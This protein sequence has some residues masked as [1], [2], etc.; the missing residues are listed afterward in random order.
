MDLD[1]LFGVKQSR[2]VS[3]GEDLSALSVELL[4]ERRQ[5]VAAELARIDAEVKTKR[6]ARAAAE[7]VFKL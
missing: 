4:E 2:L 6:A 3:L 7:S 5:L 1:E